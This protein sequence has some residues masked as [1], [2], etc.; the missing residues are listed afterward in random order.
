MPHP[1]D[2]GRAGFQASWFWLAGVWQAYRSTRIL[3]LDFAL[4]GVSDPPEPEAFAPP[5][6]PGPAGDEGYP[7]SP[8][9]GQQ[10]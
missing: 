8:D 7:H 4:S 1:L 5:V 3:M 6:Q 2:V 9:E 10:T